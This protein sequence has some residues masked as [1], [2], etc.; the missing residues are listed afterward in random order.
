MPLAKNGVTHVYIGFVP[1]KVE[2]RYNNRLS[3]VDVTIVIDKEGG[4]FGGYLAL[5]PFS[6]ISNATS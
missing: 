1:D 5:M 6:A 3:C 4:D 2:V